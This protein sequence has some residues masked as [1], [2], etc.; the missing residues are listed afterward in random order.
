M[1]SLVAL[2]GRALFDRHD[3]ALDTE[4]TGN[5]RGPYYAWMLFTWKVNVMVPETFATDEQKIRIEHDVPAPGWKTE[6]YDTA[7][8][9]HP[10]EDSG[11][12]VM[13]QADDVRLYPV[14]DQAMQQVVS[15]NIHR[16]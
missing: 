15:G 4:A 9:L 12:K 14:W 11:S 7:R 2:N 5:D 16:H 1:T 10:P 6:M 3:V 8:I 13:I